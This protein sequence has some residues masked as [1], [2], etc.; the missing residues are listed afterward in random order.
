MC[1]SQ[2]RG[3]YGGPTPASIADPT[4][5]RVGRFPGC[6]ARGNAQG[7]RYPDQ[8]AALHSR[9]RSLAVAGGYGRDNLYIRQRRTCVQA[10]G[11]VADRPADHCCRRGNRRGSAGVGVYGGC[12]RRQCGTT[13]A[14]YPGQALSGPTASHEGPGL[15]RRRGGPAVGGWRAD[16][17]G[18]S[19]RTAAGTVYTGEPGGFVARQTDHRAGILSQNRAPVGGRIKGLVPSG[20]CR[21]QPGGGR[22]LAPGSG[23]AYPDRGKTDARCDGGVGGGNGCGCPCA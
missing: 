15:C 13:C 1:R 5:I 17:R 19:L 3:R 2:Q 11:W 23:V 9:N 16:N 18:S 21:D 6:L 4:P 7:R 10:T 20:L 22:C 8:P 12:G 14:A